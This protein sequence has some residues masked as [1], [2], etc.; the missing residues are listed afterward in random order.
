M[1]H[2]RI[3]GILRA[4]W[5]GPSEFELHRCLFGNGPA[6][7]ACITCDAHHMSKALGREQGLQQIGHVFLWVEQGTTGHSSHRVLLE[8]VLPFE[9]AS[10]LFRL[11]L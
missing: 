3:A 10:A 9:I 6:K 1:V 2:D 8:A 5:D 4:D 7:K 11:M